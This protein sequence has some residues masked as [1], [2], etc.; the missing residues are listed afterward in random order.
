MTFAIYLA[1]PVAGKYEYA[2][3]MHTL[4]VPGTHHDAAFHPVLIASA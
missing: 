2:A 3:C 4:G 1:Q